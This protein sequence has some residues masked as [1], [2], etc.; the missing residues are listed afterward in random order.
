MI[1]YNLCNE[2]IQRRKQR[3]SDNI[4]PGALVRAHGSQYITNEKQIQQSRRRNIKIELPYPEIEPPE[5]HDYELRNSE[6]QQYQVG[7]F[8]GNCVSPIERKAKKNER[9]GNWQ[10]PPSGEKV[11][12]L[13]KIN[14][15]GKMD[16]F[17]EK[18]NELAS[19]KSARHRIESEAK[20]EY[21]N[22]DKKG[23]GD[24]PN[25]KDDRGILFQ[26]KSNF[27]GVNIFPVL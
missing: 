9:S 13:H 26:E 18:R 2:R 22:Q 7:L 19:I 23:A 6:Q 24:D 21:F 14:R 10:N 15:L 5:K 4:F 25:R 1:L 11:P 17:R 27:F 20:I 8:Q 16:I 3:K 12:N